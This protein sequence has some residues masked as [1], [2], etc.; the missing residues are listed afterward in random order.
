MVRR[1]FRQ[2]LSDQQGRGTIVEGELALDAEGNFLAVRVR[3]L[4]DMGAYL[5][6]VGPMMPAIN[7]QKNLPSLYRTPIVAISTR[8]VFTNTVPIGPYRGAGRPEA[9]YVMERLVD[10]A[11]RATGRDPAALRR[12]NL[13]PSD[14]LPYRAPSGLEYDSGDF[15]AVSHAGLD[16]ADWDGFALRRRLPNEGMLRGRGLACYL[17]VTAPPNPEMGGIRF[18]PDGRVTMITGTLDYGQGHASAFAQVLVDRLGVPFELI[19]LVQGDSDQLLVGGG[20]GGSRS[21]MASGK[22]LVEAAAEVIEKGRVL[23]GHL[24]EAAPADITFE[25]GEFRIAGTDRGIT[26]LDLAAKVRETTDLPP[27]LPGSLDAA[28]V[29]QS[30]PSAFPNGCHVAEVEIDPETG[31]SGSTAIPPSTTS[32]P[33]QSHAG[34]GAGPRRRGPGHR[35]GAARARGV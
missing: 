15:A 28:L 35:P 9:N 13:I 14:A 34:G 18:E 25:A 4:A 21:I 19:D 26:L 7:M 24:L 27:D 32:A 2:F 8:C 3:N 17:E 11:A 29:S 23:A 6:A 31:R 10:A 20:T 1:A 5:T 16:K 33:G 30:P 12:Q 22:A